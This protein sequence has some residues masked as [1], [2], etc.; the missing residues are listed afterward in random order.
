MINILNSYLAQ[1]KS[2]SIPGLGSLYAD[3][4]PVVSDFVNHKLLPPQV[5]YRFDKYFDAP[6]KEFFL[7]LASKKNIADFEAIKWYNEFAYDLRANIRNNGSCEW[8]GIGTFRMEPNGEIV[9]EP[10]ATNYE[11]LP[12]IVA[13]R[14]PRAES[15]HALRVGDKEVTNIEMNELLHG[16]PRKKRGL[17]W[18]AIIIPI[19]LLGSATAYL[20]YIN[21]WDAN[22]VIAYLNKLFH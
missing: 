3:T 15:S 22:K 11:L 17:L 5:R 2:I 13:E 8:P 9:F 18:L 6:N 14:V 4:I 19:V 12:A 21:N 7:Y 20:F 16:K 10:A 1:H